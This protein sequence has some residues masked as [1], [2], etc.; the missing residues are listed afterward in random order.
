MSNLPNENLRIINALTSEIDP[1]YHEAA[2]R[3]GITDSEMNVLYMTYDSGGKRP[4]ADITATGLSKQTINSAL[5]KLEGKGYIYLEGKR[6]KTVCLTESGN[7]F[8]ESTVGKIISIENR[9]F[10]SWTKE[11][12]DTYIALNKRFIDAFKEMTEEL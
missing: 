7:E 9:I 4:L 2:R 10:G 6:Q 8:A 12:V 5:R 11:E 1:M 3:L